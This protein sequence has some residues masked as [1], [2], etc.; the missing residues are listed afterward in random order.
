LKRAIIAKKK[1]YKPGI[2][3]R[4]SRMNTAEDSHLEKQI[5][6]LRGDKRK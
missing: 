4:R 2:S 5:E 1:G 3:G 6:E